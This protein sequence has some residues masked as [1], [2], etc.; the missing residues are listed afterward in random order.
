M[1]SAV[2]HVLAVLDRTHNPENIGKVVQW[3]R[4]VGFEEISLDLIYGT[5]GETIEDWRMTIASA[6]SL[7]IS[8]ISAYALIVEQGTKLAA[9]VK[10]GEVMIPDDDETAEKYL[11]A[12]E[13]FT[14]AGMNWYELSNWSKD[15]SH[16][17]HNMAYWVG[18][19]WWGVGPGAHSHIDGRR[20]WNVK[21]PTA[22]RERLEKEASPMQEEEFLTPDEIARERI[23]LLMR[24][25]Q[26]LHARDFSLEQIAILDGY[27]AS[28]DLDAQ[29]WSAGSLTLTRKGR[30][31]ADRIVRDLVL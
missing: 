7:D 15:G 19:N 28:G 27:L 25:P 6:L 18:S 8:H 10:R 26:G 16:S 1:Q 2:P 12:D 22:Y 4:E 31:I 9:Q 23:M 24:I 30:L 11:I 13:A 14:Q 17:R 5:P 20:W 3:A 29:S 21:H